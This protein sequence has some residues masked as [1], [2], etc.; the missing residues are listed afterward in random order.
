MFTAGEE[1]AS[2]LADDSRPIADYGAQ[3]PAAAPSHARTRRYA[4]GALCALAVVAPGGRPRRAGAGARP[5]R[6]RGAA[7][8]GLGG[9][10]RVHARLGAIAREYPWQGAD[11]Q[12]V[13]CLKPFSLALTVDH[14]AQETVAWS[15]EAPD[16]KVSTYYGPRAEGL[17]LDAVGDYALRVTSVSVDGVV[18]ASGGGTVA[19]RYVRRELRDLSEADR[20]TW[21]DALALMWTVDGDEG[22][23]K[24]DARFVSSDELLALHATNSA[25]R[26]NDHF[27]NGAGFLAQH[28][29]LDE[30]VLDSLQSV[31]AS[32]STPYWD[33]TIES[34]LVE[35]RVIS[36]P[37][38]TPLWTADWF[39]SL[40][41][42]EAP[43]VV[44]PHYGLS[45][46]EFFRRGFEAW[47]I[48]DGRWAYATV[49]RYDDVSGVSYPLNSYGFLRSP[50]NNNPSPYVTRV[51]FKYDA[52]DVDAGLSPAKSW[53]TCTNLY[54]FLLPN[55]TAVDFMTHL[56]D[57]TVHANVHQVLGGT[58]LD[59]ESTQAMLDA[60]DAVGSSAASCYQTVA[61]RHLWRNY[62]SEMKPAC[63]PMAV[64]TSEDLRACQLD[65][66]ALPTSRLAEIGLWSMSNYKC[67]SDHSVPALD[68]EGFAA[69][70]AAVCASTFLKGEHL[71]ASGTTDPSFFL[72][73]PTLARYY[74]IKRLMPAFSYEDDWATVDGSS[75]ACIPAIGDCFSDGQGTVED[76]EDC[77]A[78]H[79]RYSTFYV[80]VDRTVASAAKTNEAVVDA[81]DPRNAG[82]DNLVFHHLRFEHCDEDFSGLFAG[83]FDRTRQPGDTL[84]SIEA[85]TGK[86]PG[87]K[88]SAEA[89]GVAGASMTGEIPIEGGLSRNDASVYVAA[90]SG[91]LEAVQEAKKDL[92]TQSGAV[93][94]APASKQRVKDGSQVL[95]LK[96]QETSGDALCYP[97]RA[98]LFPALL[99]AKAGFHTGGKPWGGMLLTDRGQYGGL[100]S[101][102]LDPTFTYDHLAALRPAVDGYDEM[103]DA[104]AA[105]GDCA[106]HFKKT[107][108]YED[109][110][111]RGKD[112][113]YSGVFSCSEAC[114]VDRFYAIDDPDLDLGPD[115]RRS[116]AQPVLATLFNT[117][118]LFK[119]CLTP[120]YDYTR[121]GAATGADGCHE[122]IDACVDAYPGAL[123]LSADS[124]AGC[125]A[126]PGA[127]AALALEPRQA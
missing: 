68:A 121:G 96:V 1:A 35:D 3:S 104:C 79:F 34:K 20:T 110:A 59:V 76:P 9:G 88:A 33:W 86:A 58:I 124:D 12:V 38:D 100:H 69:V 24:Y 32:I 15:L 85:A 67:P 26:D 37:L 81:A 98:T 44:G 52:D 84:E 97:D 101:D 39:G 118:D 27:H 91:G 87:A 8:P 116:C 126:S 11:F 66:D 41:Y 18:A 115:E 117:P 23:K 2:L 83:N 108:T 95:E 77:C 19:V 10:E 30:M 56:E 109:A 6:L 51:N 46:D 94:K 65:C 92:R 54:D 45:T 123:T 60:Y 42:A 82:A 31:D 48:R 89:P 14:R 40:N 62:F 73:H 72:V 64:S 80:D 61:E 74:Q 99:Q 25:L 28:L 55:A 122:C 114:V 57:M 17:V 16:R 47:A 71:E 29:R 102:H 105:G 5:D 119:S 107:C 63:D 22:R 7:G 75:D 4:A 13:D 112:L 127:Y 90:L 36:S 125:P 50:W 70:G 111:M 113:A 106:Y 53:P 49:K 78:G 103:R 93:E 43:V 120:D 21:L